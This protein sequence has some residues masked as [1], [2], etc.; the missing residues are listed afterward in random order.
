MSELRRDAITGRYVIIAPERRLSREAFRRPSPVGAMDGD[1]CPFCEGQEALAGREILAWRNP[2]TAHDGPGWQVRVV[3]NREP[4]LRIEA[5]LGDATESLFQ[6]FGG[7]GAH[8]VIIESPD[9]RATLATM[10]GE[11]VERVLWAWRER[12]RDLRRDFRFESFLIVKNFGAQAGAT[13]DHP[14]SQLLAMPLVP[15]HLEDELSGARTYFERRGRCVFCDLVEHEAVNHTRV[16]SSDDRAIAFAPFAAR[17]P[18]ETWIIAREHCGPL[19]GVTDAALYAVA[20]RLH[21][22]MRR[23]DRVLLSPAFTL[24]LHAAPVEDAQPVAIEPRRDLLTAPYPPNADATSTPDSARRTPDSG[25][26]ASDPAPTLHAALRTSHPYYH[27][28]IEVIPR[29]LAVPG[30]AWDG[31]IHINPVPPEEAAQ[32]LRDAT[33]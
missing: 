3:A 33:P 24:L 9:H 2:G 11:Q 15:Q 4:A 28:H 27:W 7:L 30:L 23:L 8:E 6:W 14:H 13:L 17:V 5:Q 16:I 1:L 25:L 19:E 10:A 12:V 21:D 18:F 22:V 29:L 20:A 32:A 26:R 31:G